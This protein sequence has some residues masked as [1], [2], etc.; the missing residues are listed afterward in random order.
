MKVKDKFMPKV[1]DIVVLKEYEGGD[2]AGTITSVKGI[3]SSSIV[4][5]ATKKQGAQGV[6]HEGQGMRNVFLASV[7]SLRYATE[8]ES[9]FYRLKKQKTCHIS[10]IKR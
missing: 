9:L 10:K 2:T 4:L 1:K 7:D 3:I 5:V 6:C 8:K